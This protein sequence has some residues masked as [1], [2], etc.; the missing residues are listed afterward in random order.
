MEF[1]RMLIIRLM[2]WTPLLLLFCPPPTEVGILFQP[3]NVPPTGLV[4]Y[5]FLSIMIMG[6]KLISNHFYSPSLYPIYFFLSSVGPSD[7]PLW[8]PPLFIVVIEKLNHLSTTML[9][10]F[11]DWSVYF[12]LR[13]QWIHVSLCVLF[14]ARW[15]NA[16]L[17]L[18]KS[19]QVNEALS[20]RCDL[21]YYIM[22]IAQSH[23][24]W[25]IHILLKYFH[26]VEMVIIDCSQFYLWIVSNETTF[27]VKP[28]D[29]RG[30][31]PRFMLGPAII[32]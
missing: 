24:P 4:C 28:S 32:F 29:F 30:F 31:E 23:P 25:Y 7:G 22:M 6:Y 19:F 15:T 3:T 10:S 14:E 26:V 27:P 17:K 21:Q 12:L 20:M 1:E 5:Y 18:Q 16:S 13:L 9:Q 8:V 11:I 2:P